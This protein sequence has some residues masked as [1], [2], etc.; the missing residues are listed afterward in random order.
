MTRYRT[1]SIKEKEREYSRRYREQTRNTIKK[2]TEQNVFLERELRNL[3]LKYE[4][5]LEEN[6]LLYQ[7]FLD[8]NAKLQN[9]ATLPNC[10][11]ETLA[12]LTTQMKEQVWDAEVKRFLQ[13]F[14]LN[15][16]IRFSLHEFQQLL[17]EII[18]Q[19]EQLTDSSRPTSTLP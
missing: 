10:D 6:V 15:R 13:S 7:K 19:L 4:E 3:K 16:T 9:V 1:P 17:E 8:Y 14:K 5:L 2:L 11:F 18:P 12:S